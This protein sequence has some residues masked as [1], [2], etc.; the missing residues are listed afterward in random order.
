MSDL[1]PDKQALGKR[2]AAAREEAG[3]TQPSAAEALSA[4][5]FPMTK[6]AISHW[7]RGRNVPDALML[8]RLARLYG[9][10]A[11]VLL[12]DQALSPEAARFATELDQLEASDREAFLDAWRGFFDKRRAEQFTEED[13]AQLR[14]V[15]ESKNR[16]GGL[17]RRRSA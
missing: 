11:D 14:Q 4:L 17:A 12:G 7:E 10:S 3:Y 5:G 1:D 8:R 16:K 9:A 13:A 6:Q 2:L 15:I